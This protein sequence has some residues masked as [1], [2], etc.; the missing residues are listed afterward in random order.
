MREKEQ[1]PCL[2]NGY[3]R[4]L[5]HMPYYLHNHPEFKEL[6]RAVEHEKSIERE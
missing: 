3:H 6:L 5:W 1:R 4:N 2:I